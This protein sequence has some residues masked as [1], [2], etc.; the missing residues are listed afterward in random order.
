MSGLWDDSAGEDISHQHWQP[1]F[2][3]G[4]HMVN[5]ESYILQVVLRPLHIHTQSKNKEIKIIKSEFACI[6]F[7]ELW[8]FSV[9]QD[10]VKCWTTCA[11]I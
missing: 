11:F 9:T 4:A 3:P 1:K 6:K 7:W 10:L 8:R 2:D 5:R